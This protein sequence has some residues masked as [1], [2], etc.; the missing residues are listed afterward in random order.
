MPGNWEDWREEELKMKR[1]R[2]AKIA[3]ASV[4]GMASL[5]GCGSD[6]GDTDTPTEGGNGNGSGTPTDDLVTA[7]KAGD[8]NNEFDYFISRFWAPSSEESGDNPEAGAALNDR[9]EAWAQQN[10]EFTANF[11][12]QDSYDEWENQLLIDAN[13]GSAPAG[14]V[15]DNDW[16]GPSSSFLRPINDVLENDDELD[17]PQTVI[18]DYLPH[19]REVC[20]QDGEII[21]AWFMTS[22]RVMY[23]REDLIDEYNDGN[24]PRT[25]DEVINVG[26]TLVEEISG[27]DSGFAHINNPSMILGFYWG[28]G[29]TFVDDSGAPDLDRDAL[30]NVLD[31]YRRL[32]DEGAMS[33]RF[34][35]V[36][37]FDRIAQEAANGQIGMFIG[38]NFQYQQSV[39][40]NEDNP[41][42]W[43]ADHPPQMESDQ[44]ATWV[45]GFA[46]GT[47]QDSA[48]E[49]DE[50]AIDA[51][52]AATAQWTDTETLISYCVPG[53]EFPTRQSAFESEEFEGTFK[54]GESYR[55]VIET[56][57]AEPT[58][59]IWPTIQDELT[60]AHGTVV[61]GQSSPE[62]AA[63]TL[64]Q[65]VNDSYSG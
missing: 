14:S 43:N 44:F 12:F 61:S 59:D 1:R 2:L 20:V 62:N 4:A 52:A 58:G 3:G 57:I 15:F 9:W 65:N 45:G 42:R 34:A 38:G 46:E 41:D 37:S 36:T 39:E 7:N 40:P 54:Y 33:D 28:Q 26:S 55:E 30:V 19:V 16:I 27:M 49:Y 50:A 6:S 13:Q 24:V 47:F 35:T 21:A 11:V 25:W 8:G 10:P 51:A 53:A 17:D 48:S 23:Y 64:I 56:G 22:C 63:D 32:V 5:A 29:A 60:A 18:D 31:F